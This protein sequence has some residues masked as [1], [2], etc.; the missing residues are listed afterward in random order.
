M[1]NLPFSR[2]TSSFRNG[3]SN[4]SADKQVVSATETPSFHRYMS[5]FRNGNS[6]HS[7]GIQPFSA[8]E[9]TSFHNQRAGFSN[10]TP[11]LHEYTDGFC[12]RNLPILFIYSQ[13]SLRKLT[14]LRFTRIL[15]IFALC[16]ARVLH[17]TS[18]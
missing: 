11:S 16:L 13:F 6:H 8:M 9:T 17:K 15:F 3:N 14:F 2:D 1:E 5:S 10:R 7:I 12:K 18:N 4:N